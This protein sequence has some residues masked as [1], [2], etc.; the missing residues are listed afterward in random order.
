MPIQEESATLFSNQS[1]TIFVLDT[2]HSI[3]QAQTLSSY[4]LQSCAPSSGPPEP[5]AGEDNKHAQKRF[6]LSKTPLGAPYPSKTEPKSDS[7]R[8]KVLARIPESER[9]FH[10]AISPIVQHALGIIREQ[11]VPPRAEKHWCLPRHV[12]EDTPSVSVNA[13]SGTCDSTSAS[14]SKKRPRAD[15]VHQ[16]D[17]AHWNKLCDTSSLDECVSGLGA[18]LI[19]SSTSP[20]LFSSMLELDTIVKNPSCEPAT[21]S[22]SPR[23]E[24]GVSASTEYI[25][26]PKSNFIIG[27]LPLSTPI[28][29]VQPL[30]V[31]PGM[32]EDQ[33][34]NLLLFDPPW[35]NKSVRRS[36]H[37][38][39]HPY[40]EMDILTQRLADILHAHAYQAISPPTITQEPSPTQLQNRDSIAAI[41]ITNSEKA[42]RVAYSILSTSGFHVSE[43]WIWIK[44]TARGE[45]ICPV[46]A[47]WR[48]PY[49]ILVIGRRDNNVTNQSSISS[50]HPSPAS[51][52]IFADGGASFGTN[53]EPD[54]QTLSPTGKNITRRV[55]AAVPDIHSRKPN[56][57]EL[58]ERIFFQ[59]MVSSP[60]SQGQDSARVWP[61]TALEVF[62]RNLTAGWWACGNEVL[63]FNDTKCWV[64]E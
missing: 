59:G 46:D 64:D 1:Q 58:F 42:R 30:G 33:K 40:A 57:R 54:F 19:L 4:Q 7:A 5:A 28:E 25:I 44:V 48:K 51:N 24:T 34:F 23:D 49:E 9:V 39:T 12:E 3:A 29:C 52:N 10:A 61:Y 56:L 6:L 43:E 18:P 47:L 36:R 17:L 37:Y 62:A 32:P 26:P 21:L 63:K 50:S 20:N 53:S 41:W 55:I 11:L 2:P 15:S 45:P 38:Q 13:D 22:I 35:P 14:T 31:I 16:Y 8:A 27:N 60:S